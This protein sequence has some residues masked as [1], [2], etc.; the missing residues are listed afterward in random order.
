MRDSKDSV[1]WN[2]I[3]SLASRYHCTL[4]VDPWEALHDDSPIDR[5]ENAAIQA[6]LQTFPSQLREGA[7]TWEFSAH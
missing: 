2:S 4:P 7:K 3:R 6:L 1:L 5:T